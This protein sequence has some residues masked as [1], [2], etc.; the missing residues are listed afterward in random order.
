M[1]KSSK[2][3]SKWALYLPAANRWKEP[4]IL[5]R[6]GLGVLLAA[7]LVVAALAFNIFGL[8]SE[9]L[10][11]ELAAATSRMQAAQAKLT[12]SRTLTASIG[13]GKSEGDTFLASYLTGRRFTYSTIIN[14]ITATAKTAGIKTQE[15]TIAPLDPIEGSE[16]LSMMS[17]SMNFEGGYVQLVKFVNL[18]DR[19]PRFL[20]IDSMQAAPQPKGDLLTGNL[21]VNAFIKDDAGGVL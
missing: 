5:V 12:R 13:R 1:P 14:E 19:S 11:R 8:S 18:L 9:A 20:I 2:G 16:D 10:N 4:R 7:N 3:F 17:I 6:A 15:I 21:K